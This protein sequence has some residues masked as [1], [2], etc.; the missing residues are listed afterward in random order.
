MLLVV[1]LKC[2]SKVIFIIDMK[3][4]SH[5]LTYKD[6]MRINARFPKVESEP[7]EKFQPNI[8][9]STKQILLV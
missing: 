6:K 8:K 3:C 2:C 5:I 1:R 7:P 9:I 4:S